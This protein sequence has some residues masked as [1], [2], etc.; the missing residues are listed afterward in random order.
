MLLAILGLSHAAVPG[1]VLAAPEGSDAPTLF[2]EQ[3]QG[4]AAARALVCDP[5]V[6]GLVLCFRVETAGTRRYVTE[7]DLVAWEIDRAALREAAASALTESP[8]TRVEIEGGGHYWQAT[9]A[10]GREGTVLL[11]PEWLEPVGTDVL[12]AVPARGAL[13]AWSAGDPE[14]DKIV[15]VGARQMFDELDHPVSPVVLRYRGGAWTVWGQ[16]KPR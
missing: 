8:L 13:V 7:A 9:A 2:R 6:D 3:T 11:H 5:V 1:V 10:P 12:V 14:L 15:A 16:A 4:D